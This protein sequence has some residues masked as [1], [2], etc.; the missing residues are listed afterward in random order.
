MKQAL[1]TI[2]KDCFSQCRPG[3]FQYLQRVIISLY[4]PHLSR[5]YRMRVVPRLEI[6]G[7]ETVAGRRY[8]ARGLTVGYRAAV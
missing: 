7:F 4:A 3:F 2:R 8:P 6:C 1:V 5:Q